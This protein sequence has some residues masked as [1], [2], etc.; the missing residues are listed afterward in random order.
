M[1]VGNQNPIHKRVPLVSHNPNVLQLARAA[2][3]VQSRTLQD[4]VIRHRTRPANANVR[5][6]AFRVNH[7]LNCDG[8][9]SLLVAL[10]VALVEI[11]RHTGLGSYDWDMGC[12]HGATNIGYARNGFELVF[13]A[14]Q[15]V[16]VR[17][18]EILLH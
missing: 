16:V 9:G 2:S 13:D 8:V 4:F 5:E 1:G 10:G 18:V 14:L 6:H 3:S 12:V 17:P 15:S 7:A 11:S